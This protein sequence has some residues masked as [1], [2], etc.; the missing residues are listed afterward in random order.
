MAMQGSDL[1]ELRKQAKMTQGELADAIGVT[2]QFIG[3]MERGE[4][5]IEKRT[6]LAVLYIVE[7]VPGGPI[8][9]AVEAVESAR[10]MLRGH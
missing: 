9:Q 4:R 10:T 7:H 1:R 5:A 8:D 2:V 3:M 6:E